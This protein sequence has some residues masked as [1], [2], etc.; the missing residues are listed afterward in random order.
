[1]KKT[2]LTLAVCALPVVASAQYTFDALQQS[3]TELRGTSRFMSMGGAFGALGGDISVMNQNPGGIG[4]YRSSDLGLTVS[5]DINSVEATSVKQDE[6]RFKFNNV[7]YVGS[8]K[9]D[10]E[11]MPNVNF[12]FSYSR[13]NS[14]DRRYRGAL[15]GIP[16]SMTNYLADQANFE[17]MTP[18][19]LDPERG[20]AFDGDG[21][22]NQ[23]LAYQNYLIL[24]RSQGGFDG[25]G[26]DGVV[27]DAEFEVE[28]KGHTDEFSLALGGNLSNTLYWGFAFG[29][30]DLLYEYN[31][32]YGEVLENTLVYNRPNSA[33]A[34]LVDG[35]MSFGLSDWNRTT[36][37][38]YNFKLGVILKPVKEFRL[39][40]A[41]HTPTY[42]KMKDRYQ[43]VLATQFIPDG[44]DEYS[45][46]DAWTPNATAY[47]KTRT[48]WRFIG[49][50]A[51]VLGTKGLLSFDYEYV[52]NTNIRLLDDYGHEYA[53]SVDEVKTYLA[54]QHVVRVGGELRLTPKWSL[55]AGYNY[56]TSNA[57]QR[58]RDGEEVVTVGGCNPSYSYDRS[59]QNITAGLG[60]HHKNVYFDL[61]YVHKNR[62]STYEAFPLDDN[63]LNVRTAV[64]EHDNK[65]SATL[66]F[67]F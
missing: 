66:G 31:R 37:T 63:G 27:G 9:L 6:T 64:S 12:G 42:Y 52:A 19:K 62:Q 24:P 65:I 34:T 18:A 53:G 58:V 48:P 32:Y 49:S 67:R 29:I 57:A 54:P 22:W 21:S 1:M 36:G 17:G 61:A 44:N 50:V 20:S 30:T 55:R 51:G 39:G 46:D 26:F 40:V 25:L 2:I 5:L 11:T 14:F 41:F 16:T 3:Q 28:E 35:N 38:G 47:Y 7:G 10:S 4:V 59:V 33:S 60:Y 43:S 13:L 56:Q 45:L 23:V 15:R 8:I